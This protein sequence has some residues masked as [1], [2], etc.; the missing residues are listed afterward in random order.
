M[1]TVRLDNAIENQLNFLSQ[2]KH[3]SKSTIVKE[4]LVHYFDMIKRTTKQKSPYE[5]GSDL[6]GKYESG[7]D[8]LSTTY[9]QKLKNKINEKNA[10]R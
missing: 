9:K 8:D 5:L 4:A 2:E 3:V 10:H 1:L 7:R 6:F